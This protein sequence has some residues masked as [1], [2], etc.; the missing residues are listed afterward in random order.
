MIIL[1]TN[2]W[3]AYLNESDSLHRKAAILFSNISEQI[4]IPEYV[5]VEASNILAVRQSHAG[6]VNFL[7][8]A[9]ENKEANILPSNPDFLSEITKFFCSHDWRGLS[10]VGS[11]LLYLSQ[12]Y[13]VLTFDKQ[14]AR[15]IK[16]SQSEI[17]SRGK[18]KK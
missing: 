16:L 11:T 14:L 12:T 9:L 13:T 2:V 3:I 6:A 18:I 17:H 10:F 7:Q 15:A 8:L 1:D 4:I 5:L